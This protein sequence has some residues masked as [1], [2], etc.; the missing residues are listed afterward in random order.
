MWLRLVAI[1]L[2]CNDAAKLRQEAPLIRS[3]TCP[4]SAPAPGQRQ[5]VCVG[6]HKCVASTFKYGSYSNGW[7]CAECRKERS[8]ERWFCEAC[9]DNYC[10]SCWPAAGGLSCKHP[11][12]AQN[13]YRLVLWS[14]LRGT[15]AVAE[16]QLQVRLCPLLLD[17]HFT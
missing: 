5:P 8:G 13:E 7:T 4:P 12:L 2:S 16:R 1:K 14:L 10:Y 11:H 6:G 17:E 9:S 15:G 3:C